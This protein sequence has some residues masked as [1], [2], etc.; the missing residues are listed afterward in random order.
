MKKICLTL[1]ACAM[2]M[3][4]LS[5]SAQV[6]RSEG[7]SSKAT[8]QQKTAVTPNGP[9]LTVVHSKGKAV[10]TANVESVLPLLS[11]RKTAAPG[12]PARKSAVVLPPMKASSK[13]SVFYGMVG[14]YTDNLVDGA[15]WRRINVSGPTT[16]AMWKW[17]PT[18]GL[19]YA[20]CDAGFVRD[21]KVY[22]FYSLMNT[23]YVLLDGGMVIRDFNTGAILDAI[24]L[25]VLEPNV[26]SKI[27]WGAAYDEENDEVYV[28]T[29][30]KSGNGYM[31]QKYNPT[32]GAYTDLGVNI[33]QDWITIAWHPV[34]KTFYML[35]D[36]GGLS[37]YDTRSKSFVN[38]GSFSYNF[39]GY[40]LGSMV[41]SPNDAAF[42]AMIDAYTLDAYGAE[43]DC[44]DALL[45]TD[46]GAATFLGRMEYNDVYNMLYCPDEYV[47]PTAP[48]A[49]KLV[50]MNV[51]P[52][53]TSGTM[54]VTLPSTLGNGSAISGTVYLKMELDGEAVSSSSVASGAAGSNVTVNI[55][56]KTQGVHKIKLIPRI[57][58][59]TGFVEGQPLVV[60]HFFGND[61]PAAPKNVKLTD[62]SVSWSAVTE[63]ARGGAINAANVRYEVSIDGVVM[64]T[65]PVSGTSFSFDKLPSVPVVGHVA[66]VVAIESGNRSE[67]GVSNKLYIDYEPLMLPVFLGPDPGETE[68]DQGMI[69]LFTI[70]KDPKNTEPLRGW[71]YDDQAAHSGGFYCLGAN[72]DDGGMTDPEK[73]DEW[74]F[75]PAINFPSADDYYRF[76]MEVSTGA[77][78]FSSTETYE[79]VLSPVPERRGTKTVIREATKITQPYKD[80][81]L[82]FETSETLFQVP[83]AG[84]YYIGI[85]FISPPGTYRLYARNFRVEGASTTSGSPAAVTDLDAVASPRGQLS[86]IV[87]FNMPTTTLTGAPLPEGTN[88]TATVSTEAGSVTATAAAGD[89][90]SVTVPAIQGLNSVTVVTSTAAGNGILAETRVYCGAYQPGMPHASY[91]ITDDNKTVTFTI[92]VDEY[93]DNGE[94]AGAD[95]CSIIV[96]RRSGYNWIKAADLGTNRTWQF[97]VPAEYANEQDVYQFG[98]AAQN[99]VGTSAEMDVA[100]LI[101]G[102]PVDVPFADNFTSFKNNGEDLLYPLFTEHLS[103]LPGTWGFDNPKNW[104]EMAGNSTNIALIAMW[105]CETQ[106]SLAKFSTLGK[107]NVKADLEIFFGDKMPQS[108]DVYASSQDIRYQKVASYDRSTADGWQHLLVN[109]PAEFQNKPWVELTI[110]TNIVGYS[111]YF[112]LASYSVADYPTDM[113]TITSIK[114]NERGVVGEKQTLTIDVTNAGVSEVDMPQYTFELI[115]DNGVIANDGAVNPPAK[116]G[117]GATETLTFE[118]TPKVAHIG[119]VVARFAIQ[120]Q[121]EPAVTSAQHNFTIMNAPVP[122]V[123]DLTAV[124]TSD[125]T[126]VDLAWSVPV[127]TE[128]FEAADPWSYGS[129]LRG[130][131]NI[132]ADGGKVW[133]IS[134]ISYPGKGVAKGYQVFSQTVSTNPGLQAHSGEQCLIVMSTTAGETDDWLISPQVAGGSEMSFWMNVFDPSYPET[135]FVM[136]STTDDKVESFTKMVDDG[137]ICPDKSGWVKYTFRLPAGAKYFAL[138]HYSDNGN[139]S[140]GCLIDDIKYVAANP[141]VKIESY[142]VYRSGELLATVTQPVYKDE[143]VDLSGDPVVYYVVTNGVVGGEK[144]SSDISNSVWVDKDSNGINDATVA[145]GSIR[146][147]KG[148]IVFTGFDNGAVARVFT[149]D[150]VQYR[151]KTLGG[152]YDAVEVPAGMYVVRCGSKI[153]KVI[154]R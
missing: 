149:V 17:P 140:F 108:I 134:E 127:Y 75:L 129:N 151:V 53:Q 23:D 79:V 27:V 2:T 37:K 84:T 118:F 89:P 77:H 92:D 45:I 82:V 31:L 48:A 46:R 1:L 94:W 19:V 116:L 101:L 64:T 29:S 52:G 78:Y 99:V 59:A 33:G 125:H 51:T 24:E 11:N 70:V 88:V 39:S 103:Y 144:T 73:N 110:R 40:A 54:T 90:C 61:V 109:L 145:D 16:T 135:I 80:S 97:T 117:V 18:T 21:G 115:G 26:L 36:G 72:P 119:N 9:K 124:P 58:G 57:Q 95:D 28:I 68:M 15:G 32:N 66:S 123:D 130:F 133:G 44:T 50:S 42:F 100:G 55:D 83:S 146:A 121:P 141:V 81:P 113:V 136:Y 106:V 147:A 25:D 14:S 71:R 65:Q 96:Y 22:A 8:V 107:H 13:G 152:D 43:V 87:S 60:E 120:G 112:M 4:T 143:N 102:P 122:V 150:G 6:T 93:N 138:R 20:H 7:Q 132:D 148:K 98:F 47:N 12:N 76:T 10:E 41:Y 131:T 111:S 3:F 126:K 153:A 35:E 154:V 91:K 74:L 62:N 137:Y 38:V 86:A 5:A 114:G 56:V 30:N 139:E 34:D 128:S 105:E 104:D 69:D 67:P 85:H 63:G 142:S 49:P